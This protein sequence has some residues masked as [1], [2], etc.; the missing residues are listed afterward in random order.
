MEIENH[1]SN[2]SG[3]FYFDTNKHKKPYIN[4][5]LIT[6]PVT[7]P[8]N[9]NLLEI[10]NN[11]TRQKKKKKKK[12]AKLKLKS[13][14]SIQD[15]PPVYANS[16]DLNILG[17]ADRV[18]VAENNNSNLPLFATSDTGATGTYLKLSDIGVLE[19][20][21][22]SSAGD[23]IVVAVADGTLLKSTHHGFLSIPGHGKILAHVLPQL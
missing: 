2:G 22:L 18:N 8:N 9:N 12:K 6:S 16:F 3:N 1:K 7:P 21:T 13:T 17:S 11:S 14:T 4:K 20:I 15:S 10:T 5:L 23:Q 19:D